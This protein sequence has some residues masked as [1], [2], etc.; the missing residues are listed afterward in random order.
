MAMLYG[1]S[2]LGISTIVGDLCLFF[3]VSVEQRHAARPFGRDDYVCNH[4]DGRIE[5]WS[6]GP[7]ELA[8]EELDTPDPVQFEFA[9]SFLGKPRVEAIQEYH[10][11][12]T[13]HIHPDFVQHIP[14][15][16][17]SRGR[18]CWCSCPTRGRVSRMYNR[19]K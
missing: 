12:W 11:L 14:I 15:W 2:R 13:E 16:S 19:L 10:D 4:V 17:C 7:D 1:P 3:V 5:P 8:P 6:R 18:L 9:H